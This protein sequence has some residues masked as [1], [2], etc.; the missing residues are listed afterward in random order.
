ML[1]IAE[2]GR[3]GERYILG[4]GYAELGEIVANLGALTGTK[5]PKMRIP[6]LGALA[7]AAAAET[8]SRITRTPSVISLAAIRLMNA[9]LAVTSAKAQREL[10]VTFR[11][12]ATTLADTVAWTKASLAHRSNP[13]SPTLSG[14]ARQTA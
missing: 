2:S 4:G 13:A 6:Y 1:R 7:F 14:S 12:F 5:P 3:S 11:P 9:R 10:G 8:W